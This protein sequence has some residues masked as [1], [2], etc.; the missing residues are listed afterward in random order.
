MFDQCTDT[1]VRQVEEI[2]RMV[3]EFSAFARMPKPTKEPADLKNILRDA[4]FLREVSR[5][6]ISFKLVADSGPIQGLFD[7]RMLGQAFS[8]LIKNAS[9]AIDAVPADAERDGRRIEVRA[10]TEDDQIVVDVID[11]GRGLPMENRNRILEPY[12]TMREKGTGLGLAIVK[13]IVEDHD[14]SL[15]LHDA[16][17]DFDSGRGAMVR[18]RLSTGA[19][20]TDRDSTM[21]EEANHHGV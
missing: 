1:I 10:R 19:K 18:V 17:P 21:L 4:I 20:E 15:E 9:E 8:N 3:D 6:D 14:G 13:K 7:A 11:N 12:I 2:G 16:P 5:N